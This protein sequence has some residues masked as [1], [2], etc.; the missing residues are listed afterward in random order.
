MKHKKIF[1]IFGAA[2]ILT[3]LIV[4][5]LPAAPVFAATLI[6]LSPTQGKVGDPINF[7]G[8]GWPVISATDDNQYGI[9]LYLSDQQAT[10]SGT[11][12]IAVTRYKLL[13]SVEEDSDG[14]FSGT[15]VIPTTLNQGTLG[16]STP[17]TI[18]S[19]TYYLYATNRYDISGASSTNINYVATFTITPGSTIELTPTSGPASASVQITGTNFPASTTIIVK[20][21]STAVPIANGDTVTRTTGI[22]I[23]TIAIPSGAVTGSQTITVTAGTSTATATFT[24]VASA[25]LDTLSPTSGPAGTDVNISGANFPAST[26]LSF[27]FDTTTVT[28]K[29]GTDAST[30]SSGVFI[31]TITVPSGAAAGAH[32]ITVT[33]GTG[34]AA[35]TFTVTAPPPTSTTTTPPPPTSTTTTPPPPTSTTT[36]P[37]PGTTTLTLNKSGDFIGSA[38][39]IGGS[40][41]KKNGTVTLKYDDKTV[42]TTTAD[43]SG[44]FVATF[45]VPAS[46]HGSH[47]ITATDGTNTNTTTFEVEAV[48]PKTPKPLLPAMGVTMKSPFKFDWEDVTDNSTPV[49]YKLQIAT[50]PNFAADTIIIDKS[51]LNTSEYIVSETE[52]SKLKTDKGTLY[53]REKAIDSAQNESDWT[54]AGEF[55]VAQPFKFAGW[56][57]ILIIVVGAIVMWLFGFWIGRKT[58]FY[59]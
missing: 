7:N 10:L 47:T 32:T 1:R 53:W 13:T 49:T 42:G 50:A 9:D 19:G 34:T 21:G 28:P 8:S 3:L 4:A 23:T 46:K 48:A 17:L 6:T 57:M 11:I 54:G 5:T 31:S 36:T 44:F 16:T 2:I 15:F 35:A 18:V 55:S 25:A 26:V 43:A 33:A 20:L 14:T 56:P 59:Y 24:V 39:G 51:G 40:G 22:L 52:V 38:V 58:A 37:K 45:Q 27:T 30:R 12:G 41:F 29:A